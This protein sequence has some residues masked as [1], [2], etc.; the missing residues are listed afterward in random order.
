M[1]ASVN[2]FPNVLAEPLETPNR[3][4]F[5][6]FRSYTQNMNH[7]LGNRPMLTARARLNLSV[8]AVRHIL[9]VQG[10]HNFLQNAS[11]MEDGKLMVKT[12]RDKAVTVEQPTKFEF[13]INLKTAK[14][15][16][17]TIPP[18]VLARADRV[19]K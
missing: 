14:Q 8:Q 11:I 5:G 9:D 19:I 4:R 12:E 7:L 16:G 15:I 17:L 18:H 2:L 13:V 10:C 1:F 3:E 6:V